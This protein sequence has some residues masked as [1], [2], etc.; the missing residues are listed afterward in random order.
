MQ[1]YLFILNLTQLKDNLIMAKTSFK[2]R[3][4]SFSTFISTLLSI[5]ILLLT[6]S[7][8]KERAYFQA[9]GFTQG[10]TY[11]VIY[12]REAGDTL[13]N[14]IEGILER[15]DT[16]LSVY[17]PNSNIS[18]I[19]R[20][21]EVVA[22]QLVINTFKR[23]KEIYYLS[24]GAFDV[25][26]SALFNIWG[27]GAGK[28]RDITESLIDSAMALKGMESIEIVGERLHIAKEGLTLN[29]NSIAK[30]YTSDLIGE[31]LT[32]L[33]VENWLVEIGGEIACRGRNSRGEKWSIGIER[34]IEGSLVQGAHLQDI[35][36]LSDGAL[37]TSG[38]YR[39]YYEK[40][41]EFFAH[42]IDPITGYPV[43]H[44]LLSATVIAPDAMTADA[45]ATWFMVVGL[46]RAIEIIE[47]NREI[48]GY[49]IYAQDGEYKIYKSEG[50]E[51][52]N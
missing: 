1:R 8:C 38:N 14:L 16:T 11:R 25:S 17:N 41:G 10:T 29:F 51:I 7:S 2:Q 36:L 48:E 15:V 21:E 3:E 52:K 5:V 24:G 33:G 27:F 18:A 20:G 45:Y 6:L 43:K 37:A 34:P 22:D 30:G 35:I 32:T 26:A 44:N 4:F 46:E 9:E 42:T 19:N 31:Q 12:S 13:E 50:V 28:K 23:A 49:L 39:R 40:D 47:S